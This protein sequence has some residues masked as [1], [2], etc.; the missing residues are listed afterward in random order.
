MAKNYQQIE[1]EKENKIIR[2][3]DNVCVKREKERR[4]RRKDKV[5]ECSDMDI[6]K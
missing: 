4:E 1:Q 5:S 3:S 2:K 6:E